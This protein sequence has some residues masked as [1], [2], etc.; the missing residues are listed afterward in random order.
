VTVLHKAD[1]HFSAMLNMM[2]H[3]C[4]V[5]VILQIILYYSYIHLPD[6]L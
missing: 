2:R 4:D 1:I 3:C 5:Y 6:Y